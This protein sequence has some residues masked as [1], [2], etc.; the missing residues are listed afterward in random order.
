[1]TTKGRSGP[2]GLHG[3]Q[4]AEESRHQAIEPEAEQMLITSGGKVESAPEDAFSEGGGDC[5]WPKLLI[6]WPPHTQS[7]YVTPVGQEDDVTI[8]LAALLPVSQVELHLT[9]DYRPVFLAGPFEEFFTLRMPKEPLLAPALAA[10]PQPLAPRSAATGPSGKRGR[11]M[12]RQEAERLA[13]AIERTKVAWL[14]VEQI[15]F[16]E[17]SKAYELK[18]R[19]RGPARFWEAGMAWRISWITSPREWIALLSNQQERQ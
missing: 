2:S 12:D 19:E 7:A 17:T 18:C 5:C 13:R 11:F 9:Y 3:F 1:M 4:T 14:H 15:V 8:F 16:N 10:F 6:T